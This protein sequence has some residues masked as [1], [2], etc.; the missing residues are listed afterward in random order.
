M[1]PAAALL[2]GQGGYYLLTGTWPLVHMRS[3]ERVTGP[4]ADDWLVR[5]VGALV[6]AIAIPL[7]VDG[8]RGEAD[9]GTLTL[10]LGS[11]AALA[12]VDVVYVARRVIS[13]IYLLDAAL[14][15]G[16]ILAWAWRWGFAAGSR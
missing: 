12:A 11:A 7:L 5:T 16:L 15:A 8:S 1:D 10:A 2:L 9:A 14:E 13:P 4:K 6:L 3:F